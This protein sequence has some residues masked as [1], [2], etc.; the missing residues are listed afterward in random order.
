MCLGACSSPPTQLPRKGFDPLG[1]TDALPVYWT[2]EAEL[3]HGRVAMLA[4]VGWVAGD[5]GFRFPGD[6]FQAVANSFE[7]HD[8][9]VDAGYMLPFLGA[10]GT[11][12]VSRRAV[13]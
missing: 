2:R 6:K 1:V 7:A 13:W 5:L 4:S 10:I 12:E 11:F 9:M 8:K 3:K